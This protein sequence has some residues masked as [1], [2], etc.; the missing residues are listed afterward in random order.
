MCLSLNMILLFSECVSIKNL[1][2]DLHKIEKGSTM[3]KNLKKDERFSF[4]P[5]VPICVW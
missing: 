2:L 5:N 4:V 1:S 3:R